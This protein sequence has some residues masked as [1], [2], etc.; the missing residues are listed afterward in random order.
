M[1]NA[2]RGAWSEHLRRTAL[3]ITG[4]VVLLLIVASTTLYERVR[5]LVDAAA[6]FLAEHERSGVIVF[7]LLSALSAMLAF[8]STAVVVAVVIGEWGRAVTV[9]LLREPRLA[10]E[11]IVHWVWAQ[12]QTRRPT[13]TVRW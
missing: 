13:A 8:F 3:L 2:T 12:I 7:L 9:A 5:A 6:P 11:G 10:S 1:R 4:S